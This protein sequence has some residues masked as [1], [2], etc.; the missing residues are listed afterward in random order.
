[1]NCQSPTRWE[2][3]KSAQFNQFPSGSP[4]LETSQTQKARKAVLEESWCV[5]VLLF[6]EQELL[7]MAARPNFRI[8]V[9]LTWLFLL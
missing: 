6:E 5:L 3:Q 7:L 2:C 8:E 9:L 1:M 4:V